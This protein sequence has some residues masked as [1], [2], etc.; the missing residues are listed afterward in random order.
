MALFQRIDQEE[1][2]KLGL[3]TKTE[4]S[5]DAFTDLHEYSMLQRF[6][7]G[8][9]LSAVDKYKPTKRKGP[10]A[11]NDNKENKWWMQN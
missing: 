1:L 8:K 7:Q 5:E 2:E 9:D 11:T 10:G 3:G 4:V 6:R